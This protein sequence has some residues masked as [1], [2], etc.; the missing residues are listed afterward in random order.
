MKRVFLLF[1]L[2]FSIYNSPLYAQLDD[3]SIAPDWTLTDLNGNEHHLYAY[4]DSGYSVVIDF[5]ATWCAP[6]WSYHNSGNLENLYEQYGPEG[7]REVMVFFIEGD[8]STSID[9]LYGT[10]NNTQGNWVEGTP[11]PIINSSTTANAYQIGYWPTIYMICQNRT[12]TEVGQQT[13]SAIYNETSKCPQPEFSLDISIQEYSPNGGIVCSD[14]IQPTISLI[15]N[16]NQAINSMEINY[17]LDNVLAGTYNWTGNLYL[18][19]DAEIV[20]P[21]ISNVTEGRHNIKIDITKVNESD[22]ENVNDNAVESEFFVN[23]DGVNVRMYFLSDNHPEESSWQI[24]QDGEV[25]ITGGNYDMQSHVYIEN[26]CLDEG[27]C[28]DFVMND[29]YGDGMGSGSVQLLYNNEAVLNISGNDF[30]TTLVQAFCV[31]AVN[32]NEGLNAKQQ[33]QIYPNPA[34][35]TIVIKSSIKGTVEIYS[36]LGQK[37]FTSYLKQN[38]QRIEIPG[39]KQGNYLVFVIGN[40][41]ILSTRLSIVK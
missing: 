5:S 14:S 9:D 24:E 40:K 19:Y 20:L 8:A 29:S 36:I 25:I 33:L 1:L 3:G 31:G 32:V 16:G 15:N 12:I 37:V 17:W 39:L 27:S 4:L 6:C 2:I 41:A 10:G 21:T 22:D 7:T 13:T 38:E 34:T 35:T 26:F 28:Y 23:P 30:D 11:Y 18:Y